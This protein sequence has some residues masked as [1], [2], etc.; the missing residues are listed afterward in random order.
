MGRP[1]VTATRAPE[2]F[3]KLDLRDRAQAVVVARDAGI[4]ADG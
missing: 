2:M 1:P 3:A 4:A